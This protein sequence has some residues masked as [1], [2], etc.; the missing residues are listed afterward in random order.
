MIQINQ[1][2]IPLNKSLSDNITI[3]IY[4]NFKD[5][6]WVTETPGFIS[7]ISQIE[8]NPVIK[9]IQWV[10]MFSLVCFVCYVE[11]LIFHRNVRRYKQ[12]VRNKEKSK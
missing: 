12:D 6:L 4:Q 9:I 10:I 3:L 8:V 5:H 11:Y 7:Y 1:V 2:I